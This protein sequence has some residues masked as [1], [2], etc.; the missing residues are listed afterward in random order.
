MQLS[1][2]SLA[3]ATFVVGTSAFAAPNA[4]RIAVSSGAS[5]VL[6]NLMTNTT[7]AAAM[8][9]L[10]IN[11]SG[12]PTLFGS[13]NFRTMVCANSPVTA[14]TAGTYASKPNGDFINFA[15]TNYAELRLNVD[16]GSFGAV[17]VLNANTLTWFDPGV[18]AAGTN[19]ATLPSG[20][21]KV[22][23][24]MDIAPNGFT[25][26]TIDSNTVFPATS[27]GIA[28]TFGVAVSGAL[29]I[30]M[31][32]AQ[33]AAGSLPAACLV[34]NTNL[35]YCVPNIGKAQMATIM[36]DNS[37]S[38]AYA[39]GVGFLTGV[40]A[41]NGLELRYARRVDTSGTQASAQNYFLG[42]PCSQERLSIVAEP[43]TAAEA[44][45]TLRNDVIGSIRVL[46][47]PGTG[48]VRAE[49]NKTDL[50]G[51]VI[52]PVVPNYAIGV[53]SG[54]NNQGSQNWKWI[55]VNG[56]AMA[57]N[58]TPAT[59]G[60]T[61]TATQK[62]GTYDFYYEAVY[63]GGSAA[64]NAFWATVSSA[65]NTIAAPVGLIDNNTLT[66]GYTKGGLACIGSASN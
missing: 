36:V 61:N 4:S 40:P 27:V 14:G 56:A 51:V 35:A 32:D 5:A 9:T 43:T 37:F 7:P 6:G 46:A 53:M 38:A 54:E 16:P 42:L 22:G 17:L 50:D 26:A 19:T 28:Q 57:E 23:G 15:G 13:G 3:L 55:R 59:A 31:F 1:K 21:V 60:I 39:N 58:A 30:K 11:A 34:T 63:I 24:I 62:N 8:R 12:T 2:I 18:G 52:G 41:D 10:C 20:H 65:L 44:P 33:K 45:E 47:A 66:V 64:G 29:Y 49:L 48:D 25:S